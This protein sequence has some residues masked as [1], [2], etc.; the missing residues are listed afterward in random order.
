MNS[1]RDLLLGGHRNVGLAQGGNEGRHVPVP[2]DA[3]ESLRW[4]RYSCGGAT[5][6]RSSRGR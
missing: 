4:V 2:L 3:A 5:S 6:A 1:I